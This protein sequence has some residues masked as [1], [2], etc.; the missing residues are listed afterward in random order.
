[1][2]QTTS[3]PVNLPAQLKQEAETWAARQ[4]VSLNEFIL[5][6]VAEKVGGLR[7]Q[8]DDLA[9]PHITYR[10]GAAGYPVPVLRGSGLR[11]QTVAVAAHR[12]GYSPAQIAEEYGLSEAQVN[13]ALAFYDVHRIEIEAA[14]TAEEKLEEAHV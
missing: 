9:F 14:I 5:W 8:L 11:V 13:D 6:A 12:W 2:E 7:Q 4:G 1:M 3:Y 10:R